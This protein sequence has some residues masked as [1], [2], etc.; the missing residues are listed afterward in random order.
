MS[1]QVLWDRCKG[2]VLHHLEEVVCLHIPLLRCVRGL[3]IP[4]FRAGKMGAVCATMPLPGGAEYCRGL[5]NYQHDGTISL[6]A[7]YSIIPRI[8]LKITLAIKPGSEQGMINFSRRSAMKGR[9]NEFTPCRQ[10]SGIQTTWMRPVIQRRSYGPL[11]RNP[12][13]PPR[14]PSLYTSYQTGTHGSHHVRS[15]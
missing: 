1:L 5:K 8:Y 10:V 13:K 12:C 6:I 9:S 15:R 2:Q 4:A 7:C 14:A 11:I 3:G